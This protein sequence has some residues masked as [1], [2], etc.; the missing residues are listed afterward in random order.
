MDQIGKVGGSVDEVL[1]SYLATLEEYHAMVE[2]GTGGGHGHEGNSIYDRTG[3]GSDSGYYYPRDDGYEGDLHAAVGSLYLSMDEP[4]RARGHL[5]MAIALYEGENIKEWIKDESNAR[6]M[7]DAKFN[8]AIALY[9]L[10]FFPESAKVHF[11]ALD[12]YEG[13]YGPDLNPLVQGLE[14]Y[15][16]ALAAALGVEADFA[17]GGDE[18]P[19]NES[20][21]EEGVGMKNDR[22]VDLERFK[23][24]FTNV[25][26]T[27]VEGAT[28][29][30]EL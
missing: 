21:T 8:L 18:A 10:R 19:Q 25:T 6:S 12:I 7:A 5:D 1:Q 9:R 3:I 13:L 17:N 4:K 26:L 23:Q 30:E 28:P 14:E 15:E 24:M 27:G 2:G 29:G 11:E 16:Q 22:L 20:E